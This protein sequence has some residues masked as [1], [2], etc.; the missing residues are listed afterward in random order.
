MSQPTSR[1]G[2]CERWKIFIKIPLR[3]KF[4]EESDSNVIFDATLKESCQKINLL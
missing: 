4:D 2:F 3:P 1:C